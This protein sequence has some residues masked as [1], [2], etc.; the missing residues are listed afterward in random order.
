MNQFFVEARRLRMILLSALIPCLFVSV[1]ADPGNPYTGRSVYRFPDYVL[2]ATKGAL[3]ITNSALSAKA[4]KVADIPN[5]L[6]LDSV[7]KIPAFEKALAAA[8]STPS[9]A[10]GPPIV[11]IVLF[12]LPGRDCASLNA[13]PGDFNL[14][15]AGVQGYKARF[16]DVIVG[17]A[18]KYPTVP[19]V[20]VIEPRSLSSLVVS[21]SVAKCAAS[22]SVYTTSITYALQQL[23][24]VSIVTYIDGGNASVLGWPANLSPAA[25]LFAKVYQ[26]AGFPKSLRGVATNIGAYN[27]L[28]SYS[29][30]PVD[31][32][33]NSSELKYIQTL[34]T[35]LASKSFPP[36][37][38]VDQS[39][40][41]NGGKG[42]TCNLKTAA[43]GLRPSTTTPDAAI[44]AIVWANR[45]G[46]SD[47]VEAGRTSGDSFPYSPAA[48]E[49]FQAY[50]ESL[51][52]RA[53]PSL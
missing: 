32:N 53:N 39:R 49:W 50:F 2:E 40:S 51:V 17:V 26:A 31:S 52:Q 24:T 20:A 25:S 47:G 13:I 15:S 8:A 33:P 35:A 29:I 42:L 44:D 9:T 46:E 19:V 28:E 4:L 14:D 36:H 16:V 41:G 34:S 1:F 22:S 27:R 12:N 10:Q 48:G 3:A 21:L 45:V 30:D 37:F 43:I 38:I 5:F 18:K 11:Q 7:N 6:W 23:D